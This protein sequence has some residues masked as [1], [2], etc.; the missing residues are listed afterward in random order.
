MSGIIKGKK[1]DFKLEDV[2]EVY[3]GP[4]GI[5]WEML[6][7]EQI[8]VGGAKETDILAE[9][10][11]ISKQTHVLDICSALGGPARHL[12]KKF[13]CKVT[14]LD[15]TKKMFDEAI[16]RT[17]QEDLAHLVSYE[18]GNVG[19]AP[20]LFTCLDPG[21]FFRNSLYNFMFFFHSF[22]A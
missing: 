5:L 11:N 3:E 4:V 9:K 16:K 2:Q 13:G 12:A 7:G 14:G 1:L 18:L 10:A 20:G 8:H 21:D 17:E 22:L 15:A 19:I 6:M